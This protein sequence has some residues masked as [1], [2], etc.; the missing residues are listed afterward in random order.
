[1]P[2]CE[3]QTQCQIWCFNSG[4]HLDYGLLSYDAVLSC[5]WL[6]IFISSLLS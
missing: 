1:M 5:R 4:T 3:Q 6:P 2:K